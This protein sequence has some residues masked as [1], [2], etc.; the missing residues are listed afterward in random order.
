MKCEN[1]F[2]DYLLEIYYNY[3]NWLGLSFIEGYVTVFTN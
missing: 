2:E 3:K 1:N